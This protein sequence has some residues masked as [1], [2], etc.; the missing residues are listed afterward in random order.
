LGTLLGGIKEPQG[1]LRG[2]DYFSLVNWPNRNLAWGWE[3][4]GRLGIYGRF[5][6][7]RMVG[8]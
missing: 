5:P 4:K 3:F 8:N 6:L 2:W 7:E 1:N